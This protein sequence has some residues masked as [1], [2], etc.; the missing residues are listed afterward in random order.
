MYIYCDDACTDT[1]KRKTRLEPG[2]GLAHL[3]VLISAE[4][5][6]ALGYAVG[7]SGTT[8]L[9]EGF[10]TSLHA[11]ACWSCREGRRLGCINSIRLLVTKL[12]IDYYYF[13]S[14]ALVTL[15]IVVAVANCAMNVL[16]THYFVSPLLQVSSLVCSARR[17]IM[18]VTFCHAG[19]LAV[20]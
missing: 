11:R 1:C 17:R 4:V 7:A 20:S 8:M 13:V 9:H 16:S 14:Q 2:L 15:P 18:V 10:A 12:V 5:H 6:L 19:T 3:V